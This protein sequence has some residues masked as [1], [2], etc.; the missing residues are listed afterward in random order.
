MYTRS[1]CAARGGAPHVDVRNQSD[2]ESISISGKTVTNIE[3]GV[4]SEI[5]GPA[6]RIRFTLYENKLKDETNKISFPFGLCQNCGSLFLKATDT[7][8]ENN[9][10]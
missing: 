8:K 10:W 7:D 4:G 6:L 5:D 9:G 1:Y 2:V 3:Q